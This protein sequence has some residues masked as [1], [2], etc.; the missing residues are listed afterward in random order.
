MKLKRALMAEV[1]ACDFMIANLK[2]LR[3]DFTI[4]SSQN[5][6]EFGFE[7]VLQTHRQILF[8]WPF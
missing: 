2:I 8:F 5:D 7:P 3:L 1:G 6:L 4:M